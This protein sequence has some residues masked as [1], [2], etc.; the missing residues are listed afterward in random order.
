MY[1]ENRIL[2]FIISIFI[3]LIFWPKDYKERMDILRIGLLTIDD[4]IDENRLIEKIR[5]IIVK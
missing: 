3:N 5:N 2:Y 4:I 1:N